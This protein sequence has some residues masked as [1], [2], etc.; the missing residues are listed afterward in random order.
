MVMA[1]E[2]VISLL[3]CSAHECLLYYTL[4]PKYAVETKEG[5]S[6]VKKQLRKEMC[7]NFQVHTQNEILKNT[8]NNHFIV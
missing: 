1:A 5:Y 8:P 4:Q 2:Y 6:A 7:I 3:R